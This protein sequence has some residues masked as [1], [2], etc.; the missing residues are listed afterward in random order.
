MKKNILYSAIYGH[1]IGDALGVPVEFFSREMLSFEPVV[2]M[3]EFGT[4]DQPNGTWSDDTSL[5][6]CLLESLSRGFCIQ[7]ISEN[8]ISWMD[9]GM[10]TSSGEVFDIGITTR[11]SINFLK[12]AIEKNIEFPSYSIDEFQNGNGSL[13]RILPL[14][15]H[16]K[17]QDLSIETQFNIIYKVSALTHGHIRSAIA[18]LVYLI[19][20]DELLV[21]KDKHIAYVNTQNRT[22]KFFDDNPKFNSE[23]THFRRITEQNIF[24]IDSSLIKSSGYVIDSLES[25]FW[26][27]LN[28]NSYKS[29]VL[30]AVNLGGDTDTTAAIT[31]SIAGIHF[32]FDSIP[33]S[34]IKALKNKSLINHIIDLNS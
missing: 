23:K 34:W 2:Q 20:L 13:M 17:K 27:F 1:A 12:N 10:F 22:K 5:S 24:S 14:L 8:F 4:H 7:N 9:K 26:C 31:G 25:S 30:K 19:M 18:C 29:S 16:L 21:I 15:F 28:S 6:L 3:R 11:N 32:G 33:Q